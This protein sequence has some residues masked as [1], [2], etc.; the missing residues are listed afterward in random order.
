LETIEKEPS[1]LGYEFGRWTG[2]RLATYLAVQTG[3][4]LSGSQ[5]RKILKQK[6][7]VYLWAK[8]S[9]EDKQNPLKRSEFKQKLAQYLDLAK[10]KPAQLQIWFWDESGFSLRVLRRKTWGKKGKRKKITGQRRRGRVNV[11]GGLRLSDKKRLC[12]FIKKG[13]AETFYEQLKQLN[14]FVLKEWLAQGNRAENFQSQGPKIV[15]ILDNASYHKRKDIIADIEKDF[16]NII[17]EF[18]PAYSPDFNLIE[19]VWHS[20]KEYIAHR[21]FQSVTE[22]EEVLNKLLNEGDLIIKWARKIKNKGN[23]VNA[24]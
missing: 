18:L 12:Y 5:V 23:A 3:I 17:L 7:Y 6:K 16:P 22:L 10:I 1:E 4:E 13:N 19:L 8:Y 11:M 2:E 15:I 20:C 24:S 21:L 9:L 14:E